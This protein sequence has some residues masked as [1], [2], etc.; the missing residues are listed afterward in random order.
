MTKYDLENTSGRAYQSDWNEKDAIDRTKCRDGIY[1]LSRQM[2]RIRPPMLT[3]TKPELRKWI[4]FPLSFY[5]E[6]I[7]LV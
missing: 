7:Q 5:A 3:Q 4:S 1:K 2:R 6:T